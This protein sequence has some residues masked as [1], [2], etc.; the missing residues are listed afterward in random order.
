MGSGASTDTAIPQAVRDKVNTQINLLKT[1]KADASKNIYNLC[2]DE[3]CKPHLGKPSLG[4]LSL[5]PL[6]IKDENSKL[7]NFICKNVIAVYR[8]CQNIR[9]LHNNGVSAKFIILDC[10][11]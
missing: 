11:N 3:V 4:V 5:L 1:N 10:L 9:F 8:H 6:S 7:F 2:Y